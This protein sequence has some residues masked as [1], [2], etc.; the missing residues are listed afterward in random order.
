VSERLAVVLLVVAVTLNA[1]AFA[2]LN[3]DR[4]VPGTDSTQYDRMARQLAAGHGFTD[5]AQPP[6]VPTQFREPGYPLFVAAVYRLSGSNVQVVVVLQALMLGLAAGVT[7]VLGGHLFGFV[8]GLIGGALFGLNSELAHYAHWLLT[9][10]PFTLLLVTSVLL[11]LRAQASQRGRDFV[12]CGV[13]FALA[14]LVRVIAASLVLPLGVVLL[15]S[16]RKS[17]GRRLTDVALLLVGFAVVVAPWVARNEVTLDRL[18]IS[19]RLG[20]TLIRRAP[21]AAEPLSEYPRWIVAAVWMAANPVSNVV[22]PISRFQWGP[23]YED[24]LIWDFHVNDMV[25]YNIRYEPVCN[26]QPDPDACYQD[27]GLAF[28][29]AYPVGYV[30]QSAFDVVT[31]LFEPLPGP[32]ALEHNGLVWLG[33]LAGAA[34][35]LRR[36]LR[37][38][39]ALVLTALGAYVGASIV[40]DTQVRYL[41]PVIPIIAVFGALPVALALSAVRRRAA[42]L[43][44]AHA[45]RSRAR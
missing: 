36:R 33:L 30:V 20:A 13:G 18:S 8:P 27:I 23:D 7:A 15:F 29:R 16:S 4:I 43:R 10:V 1:L 2:R 38:E 32:Q 40:V 34:L 39:H 22:Y 44:L 37:R 28:V 42:H 5:E 17:I 41:V 14:A 35:A 31:L 25:R 11:A 26:P 24:N 6:F 21:R 9:E 45:D 19:S 3:P 12:L